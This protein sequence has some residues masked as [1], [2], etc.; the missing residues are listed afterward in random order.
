MHIRSIEK[1]YNGKLV[2]LVESLL[3]QGIHSDGVFE[4]VFINIT[5]ADINSAP[6][7]VNLL[8][9]L[10]WENNYMKYSSM[11]QS[12]FLNTTIDE[13]TER[14]VNLSISLSEAIGYIYMATP[15]ALQ[16]QIPNSIRSYDDIIELLKTFLM[17]TK[18]PEY[19]HYLDLFFIHTHYRPFETQWKLKMQQE[20]AKYL[21]DHRYQ[22]TYPALYLIYS[23]HS[24]HYMYN[25]IPEIANMYGILVADKS[26]IVDAVDIITDND[27]RV[28]NIY[29]EKG[30]TYIVIRNQMLEIDREMSDLLKASYG[31]L[32]PE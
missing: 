16:H 25:P 23:D 11:H 24:I 7:S 13:D 30:I 10:L 3:D 4:Q 22:K 14:V 29:I 12:E 27:F 6:E 15:P 1:G 18:S 20:K 2:E 5:L 28:D 26:T 19:R 8:Y 17:D 21:Y 32:I 31:N 9:R